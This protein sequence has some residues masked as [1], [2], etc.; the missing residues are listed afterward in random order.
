MKKLIAS[1]LALTGLALSAYPADF[2]TRS[3]LNP[4]FTTIS[5]SNAAGTVLAGGITN[6]LSST[7]TTNTYGIV[8]TN[9]AGSAYTIA[10]NQFDTINLL[11]DVDFWPPL[12]AA[13]AN[14][15]YATGTNVIQNYV[16]GGVQIQIS[17]VGTNAAANSAVNFRFIPVVSTSGRQTTT[18]GDIWTVGVTASGTTRVTIKTN[19]PMYLWQGHKSLRLIDVNNTDTDASSTVFINEVSASGFT[20]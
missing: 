1:L 10:T 7:V 3:F 15:Y 14:T 9:A 20:P 2:V 4:Q 11:R 6:M 16:P 19:A 12:N 8:L 5:I 13:Y 18:A 17:I